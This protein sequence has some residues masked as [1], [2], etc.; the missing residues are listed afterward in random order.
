MARR[1]EPV[2]QLAEIP[3]GMTDKS[4]KP[5]PIPLL[6]REG[7]SAVSSRVHQLADRGT[8]SIFF[9]VNRMFIIK[10]FYALG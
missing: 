10:D 1:R 3:Y 4:K 8:S 5:H 7:R 2:R 9:M 6:K